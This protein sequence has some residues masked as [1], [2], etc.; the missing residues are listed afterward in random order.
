[1]TADGVG[2]ACINIGDDLEVTV[3]DAQRVI[4]WMTETP[5]GKLFIRHLNQQIDIAEDQADAAIGDNPVRDLLFRE[6]NIATSLT[7]KSIVKWPLDIASMI[8]QEVEHR[9]HL[10]TD[11]QS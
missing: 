3:T 11:S 4:H 1:M 8:D 9:K 5:E 2:E 6:R 7:L 10:T